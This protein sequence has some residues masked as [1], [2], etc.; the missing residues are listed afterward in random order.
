MCGLECKDAGY[1]GKIFEKQPDIID[2]VNKA[3]EPTFAKLG[4]AGFYS[5]EVRCADATKGYYIDCTPRQPSPPGE[6]MPEMYVKHCFAQALWDLANGRMPVL[7]PKHKYGAEIILTSS[8]LEEKHWLPIEFPESAKKYIRLKNHCIRD[9]KYFIVPNNNGGF[10]GAAIGFGDT[11]EA[12]CEM[13]A[14]YAEMVQG[15]DVKYEGGVMKKAQ[16][17][18]DNMAKIGIKF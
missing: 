14:K 15:E 10:F 2:N 12:A 4:I 18:I 3:M 7:T 11:V 16:E 1:V 13:A 6:L 17:G 8:W 9:K 5:T